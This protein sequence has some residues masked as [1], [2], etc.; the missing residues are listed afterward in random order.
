MRMLWRAHPGIQEAATG[1]EGRWHLGGDHSTHG[2]LDLY[3]GSCHVEAKEKSKVPGWEE[4][5]S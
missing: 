4:Y 1:G 2:V 3:R 5:V